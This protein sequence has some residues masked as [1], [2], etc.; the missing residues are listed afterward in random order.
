MKQ[1]FKIAAL[2][3][4]LALGSAAHSETKAATRIDFNKMID[5][6]NMT[7]KE[8][9]EEVNARPVA[10]IRPV[11]A[12]TSDDKGKVIDF[13]DVEIGVGVTPT[14]TDRRFDSVGAPVIVEIK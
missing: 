14:V 11:A 3:L 12:R 8:L 13:I 5:E 9:H 1:Q 4:T 2:M 10:Q 6:N 7:K